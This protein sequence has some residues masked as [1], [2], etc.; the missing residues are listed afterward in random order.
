[1]PNFWHIKFLTEGFEDTQAH[2]VM[3]WKN[4][5][6]FLLEESQLS[7]IVMTYSYA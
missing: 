3:G 1:M 7:L 4:K 6:R 2:T 5:H